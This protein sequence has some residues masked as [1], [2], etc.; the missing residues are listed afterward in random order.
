MRIGPDP[1]VDLTS[2]AQAI[3]SR[4]VDPT[5]VQNNNNT[6]T[7]GEILK[8]TM[9]GRSEAQRQASEVSRH[10]TAKFLIGEEDNLIDHLVA[11]ERSGILFELNLTIRN[12]VLDAYNEIMRTQV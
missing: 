6:G 10:E 1:F 2:R 9:T 4:I 11:S 12:K 8:I 3:K 7:F 5:E